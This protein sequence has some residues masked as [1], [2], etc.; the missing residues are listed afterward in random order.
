MGASRNLIKLSGGCV[1]AGGLVAGILLPVTA[2]VGKVAADV[3]DSVVQITPASISADMPGVTTITDRDGKPIAEVYDQYR[4]PVTS[5]QISQTMKNA[6][7]SIEDRRFYQEHGID[8]RGLLRA[9]INDS[10]G[11]SQQGGSTITQQLVKNYL[12]NVVDKDNKAA[13]MADRADTLTRKLREARTAIELDKNLGKDE[14]LTDYLNVVEFTGKV[15][16]VE[17]AAHAYFGTTAAQL[18]VPQAA[19]LAGM[20]NN[21][22]TY[23]PYTHPVDAKRRRDTV[24]DAMVTNRAIDQNAAIQAKAAPL[25]VTG[26]DV[27]ASTC[28]SAQ[29][30]AGFFCQYALSYL[31]SAGFD[32]A[33]L[34]NGGYVIKTTMD[35]RVSAAAKDAVT[36]NVPTTQSGVANTMAIVSPGATSHEVLAL[37]ANRN[38]G[39]DAAQGQ[40]TRNLVTEVSDPFGAGSVFKIFTAAAALESGAA[41]LDT[42][43]PNPPSQC[44]PLPGSKK[45]YTVHNDGDYADPI[46]LTNGLATSPNT[47][48]VGLET[49]VGLPDVVAMA[50]RLGLRTTMQS[51][52]VGKKPDPG[53]ANT[54]YSQ[55]QTQY[56]QDKPSFTLGNS[57][58]SP[59][60]LADVPATLM[61]GGIWCPP[62]PILSVTDSA[63]HPVPV[64]APACEQAIAPDIASTLMTGLSQD[65]VSGTTAASAHAAG[66]TR[67]GI[68][69]TGTTQTNQSVAFVG[70]TDNYAVSSL[71]FADSSTP[72]QLCPGNP[73]HIGTCGHGA[74]GGT[75]AAPPYFKAMRTILGSSQ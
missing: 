55:T 43:L 14:I 66:W 46:T 36:A 11:G 17:A 54:Q 72:G 75:V 23:N 29:P 61:S 51:N 22:T 65:T 19:L 67:P 12:V 50:S 63:G 3:S 68:G 27:P 7:I 10:V 47:A 60:E 73:V 20:V 52:D 53:S 13:Q 58:V 71:V 31:Q 57:P 38:L 64:N 74:F 1:V 37:V 34:S 24:I 32:P 5:D 9:A 28:F 40:T 16:G 33:K 15:Y 2:G 62:T 30:D 59:L 39:T 70:G 25:G 8:P 48:F 49:K 69:K 18:T 45:C 26:P 6:L 56:F 4:L 21:P 41:R 35:S 42:P 44:F